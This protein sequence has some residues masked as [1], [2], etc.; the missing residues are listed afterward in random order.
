MEWKARYTAPSD[1]E[2]LISENLMVFVN[3]IV[4][5]ERIR[6][7]TSLVTGKL[8]CFTAFFLVPVGG[9]IDTTQT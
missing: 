1:S 9:M 2:F 5:R 8:T 6:R 7:M 4:H 3:L